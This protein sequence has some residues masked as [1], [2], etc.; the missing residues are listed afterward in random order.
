MVLNKSL[1]LLLS[2]SVLGDGLSALGHGVLGE[3]PGQHQAH[4]GLDLPGGDRGPGRG[5][6]YHQVG[7]T[8]DN[9][10]LVV[11]GELAGLGGDPL[12]EVVHEAVHDGHGLGG[13]AGVGVHL[14]QHLQQDNLRKCIKTKVHLVDVDGVALLPLA[15]ALL[16]VPLGDSLGGFAGLDGGLGRGLG[17]HG[18]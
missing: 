18:G 1:P 8:E 12:E 17:R 10:P 15:L 13:D 7:T 3:L 14:L 6:G 2:A 16:L 5:Q 9:T 4:G 11:V